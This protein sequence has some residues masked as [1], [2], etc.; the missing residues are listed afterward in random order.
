MSR[1]KLD[2]WGCG[3]RYPVVVEPSG[4]QQRRARCL[5][6]GASGPERGD[7]ERALLALRAEAR[8]EH[9]PVP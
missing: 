2:V 9:K 3:H 8:D 6:C 7:A 1:G 4:G 5:G